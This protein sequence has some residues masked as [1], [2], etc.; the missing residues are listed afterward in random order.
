MERKVDNVGL[1]L[2][3]LKVRGSGSGSKKAVQ[4][5]PAVAEACGK[6]GVGGEREGQGAEGA[7]GAGGVPGGVDEGRAGAER[8]AEGGEEG[9]HRSA[10]E[11]EEGVGVC[12]YE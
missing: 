11:E 12:G 1:E 10:G 6:A 7:E 5:T 4:L 2:S 9:A 8:R 3:T